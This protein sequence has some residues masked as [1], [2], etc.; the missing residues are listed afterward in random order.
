VQ[1]KIYKKG[2]TPFLLNSLNPT[3]SSQPQV[4]QFSVLNEDFD[5]HIKD[6]RIS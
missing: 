1:T 6:T 5:L 3:L 4:T 2:R